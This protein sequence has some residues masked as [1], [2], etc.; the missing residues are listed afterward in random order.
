[1]LRMGFIE[2]VETIMETIEERRSAVLNHTCTDCRIERFLRKPKQVR[3]K[4]KETT[5]ESVDNT[6]RSAVSEN[7]RHS[8]ARRSR[9]LR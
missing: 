8:L 6:S 7:L 5:V 1:M 3:T 4:S 2:D 9:G